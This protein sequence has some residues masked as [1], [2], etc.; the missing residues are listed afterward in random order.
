MY[1]NVHHPVDLSSGKKGKRENVVIKERKGDKLKEEN[2]GEKN[3]KGTENIKNRDTQKEKDHSNKYTTILSIFSHR[4]V[5]NN[6]NKPS[7][8]HIIPNGTVFVSGD[9]LIYQFDPVGNLVSTI[10]PFSSGGAHSIAGFGNQWLY[11]S[12]DNSIHRYSLHTGEYKGT[13]FELS[14]EKKESKW[15][16]DSGRNEEY[17]DYT[18]IREHNE[19]VKEYE[20]RRER[21][22]MK[23]KGKISGSDT[24]GSGSRHHFERQ[25]Y[26]GKRGRDGRKLFRAF[27]GKKWR[28]EGMQH[29]R[30]AKRQGQKRGHIRG[31]NYRGKRNTLRRNGRREPLLDVHVSV[32]NQGLLYISQQSTGLIHVV[33]DEGHYLTELTIGSQPQ[34]TQFDSKGHLRVI[35]SWDKNVYVLTK[36][37]LHLRTYPIYHVTSP[38]GIF[39]DE[40][41]NM[42]IADKE[43]GVTVY[44]DSGSQVHYIS[45]FEGCTDVHVSIN[46]I[47][48]VSDSSANKVYLL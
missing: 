25:K 14:H 26:K 30:F 35:D 19:Q 36:H 33:T 9:K 8:I 45:G 5:I 41:D 46:G 32:D 39:I 38:H 11:V 47:L 37:N 34:K 40:H 24:C 1:T 13:V 23:R 4:K 12:S 15:Q 28:E 44:D 48:W 10:G 6:I 3:E 43:G 17:E 20:H 27:E 22:G 2:D 16:Q 29:Q 18:E 7:F 31:N 21:G 42:L